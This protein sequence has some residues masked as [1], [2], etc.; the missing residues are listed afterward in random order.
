M[1]LAVAE[2]CVSLPECRYEYTRDVLQQGLHRHTDGG[3]PV[4]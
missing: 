3:V 1:A 4:G 2:T